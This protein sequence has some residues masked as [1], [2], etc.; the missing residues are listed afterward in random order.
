M[1]P[2]E[3]A[4]ADLEQFFHLVHQLLVHA[5]DDDVVAG[6]DHR[7]AVGDD[8]V[9][10]GLDAHRALVADDFRRLQVAHDGGDGDALGQGDLAQAAAHHPGGIAVAVGH[11]LQGLGGAPAQG[12]DL[13][14]VGPAHVG[15]QGADG[16]LGRGNADVDGA[17][18][19]HVGVGAP[20]D[21]GQ[22]PLAAQAL[23]Q[24]GGHD[25][26]FVVV[27]EGEE[28]VHLGDVLLLQQ[29]LVRGVAAQHQGVAQAR[30]DPFCPAAVVLHQLHLQALLQGGGHP[31]ADVA[32]AGDHHP[33]HRPH[34]APQLPQHRAD[35]LA[36]GD[37]EDFVAGMDHRLALGNDGLVLAKEGGDAG[38][39]LGR[40]MLP[41]L[42]HRLAHQGAA[43]VG[44][45]RHHDQAAL[46]ELQH[47][48]GLGEIHQAHDVVGDVL[49]GADGEIHGKVLVGEKLLVLEKIGGPQAGNAGRHVEAA[50]GD[51][52]G[53]QVGLVALGHGD[54]Q[55]RIVQAGV[56]E[57]GRQGRIAAHGA[58]VEPVL[59]GGQAL[60]VVVHDGDVVGLVHQGL[61][62]AGADLAGTE[63]DDL[64]ASPNVLGRPWGGRREPVL[65]HAV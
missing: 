24:G 26:V 33:L 1:P 42:A 23:G 22:H 54:E 27:G 19:H 12:M 47:L 10:V 50:L 17:A 3:K 52:A 28:E 2:S 4:E 6:L 11:Q 46:G 62:H 32:A 51:L 18:L 48:Q 20:V 55:V 43:L 8:H 16:D 36:G 5:E 40:Q 63:N 21:Q 64:H 7:V 49:L 45:H 25:V 53:H 38:I 41:Q 59:Q 29:V 14:D 31:V 56:A 15:Q 37:D 57:D 30:R 44:P 13:G 58:Q 35:V 61:G 9:A 34:H 39:H 60:P 65:L